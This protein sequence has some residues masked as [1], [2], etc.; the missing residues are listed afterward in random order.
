MLSLGFYVARNPKRQQIAF[1]LW[2]KPEIMQFCN[3]CTRMYGFT[4][5][6]AV[7]L[8]WTTCLDLFVYHL[9]A[10]MTTQERVVCSSLAGFCPRDMDAYSTR[11]FVQPW[12]D[13]QRG[14]GS[15]YTG[16]LPAPQPTH[17]S[18]CRQGPNRA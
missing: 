10:I 11:K 3:L 14:Q 16:P 17:A 8:K 18:F 6:K 2:R 5:E 15:P 13:S 1:T 9:A 4:T 12:C 7:T